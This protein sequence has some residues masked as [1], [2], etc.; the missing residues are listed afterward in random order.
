MAKV[1]VV[2]DELQRFLDSG[3]S[4]ADAAKHF[5]VT[6]PA[7]SQRVRQSRIATTKIVAMERAGQLVEQRLTA[8]QRLEHVQDLILD[9]L[10]WVEEQAAQPGADR[11]ALI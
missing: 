9:Q 6:E 4:Q 5:G 10:L 8:S 2:P 7:I 11:L 1:K 3:H